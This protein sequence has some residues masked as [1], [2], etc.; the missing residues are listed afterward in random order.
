M[1]YRAAKL[2]LVR[3]TIY[4]FQRGLKYR[5]GRFLS[6]LGPGQYW[7]LE[8]RSAV[9]PLDIR[10]NFVTVAGQEV[11]TADGVG[12]KV[13]LAA[14]YEIADPVLAV[15]GQASYLQSLYLVLQLAVREVV[16]TA[17]VDALLEN[18]AGLTEK[19]RALAEP[20][21]QRLGLKL[22]SADFKD[23]MVS[24]DLKKS[25]AQVVRARKEGEAALERARGETAALRSLANAAR[26]VQ[27]YPNLVQ[28][29]LL[30][31][32]GESAGNTFVVGVPPGSTAVPIRGGG[33]DKP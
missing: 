20:E 3:V 7:V 21:V 29:R 1:V 4:E 12:L 18:R 22:L 11:L 14:N 25:F 33:G 2:R 27:E 13:T 24:G 16:A 9:T 23:L 8:P 19:L 26:M 32:M 17:N 10:P 15:N 31:V 6:V 5:K 30:Q 28:L